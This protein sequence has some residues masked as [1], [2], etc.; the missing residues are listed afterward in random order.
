MRLSPESS[1]FGRKIV[2]RLNVFTG[3]SDTKNL[4]AGTRFQKRIVFNDSIVN[5]D[6][7]DRN[8]LRWEVPL[9]EISDSIPGNRQ[10]IHR[11]GPDCA[12]SGMS[13]EIIFDSD[14]AVGT[15]F[16]M[17]RPLV[18]SDAGFPADEG[19]RFLKAVNGSSFHS[20]VSDCQV[21]R[22]DEIRV[23]AECLVTDFNSPESAVEYGVVFR[24]P[25]SA[26]QFESLAADIDDHIVPDN[27]I[28]VAHA[29]VK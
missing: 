28:F 21:F 24:K 2:F 19:A 27:E 17:I 1:K 15:T 9:I 12:L 5:I 6:E 8:I 14:I 7:I 29:H 11:P 23:V 25:V 18:N 13:D 10:T 22:P 20:I 3:W 26:M 4:H 16:E